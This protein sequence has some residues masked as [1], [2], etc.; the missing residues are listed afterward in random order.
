MS[1]FF[2]LEVLFIVRQLDMRLNS[3]PAALAHRWHH[4]SGI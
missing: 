3:L 1:G 4:Q 2:L